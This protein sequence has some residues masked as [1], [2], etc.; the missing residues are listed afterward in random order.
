MVVDKVALKQV[1]TFINFPP[2]LRNYLL[3]HSRVAGSEFGLQ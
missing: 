3:I 1:S 2:M